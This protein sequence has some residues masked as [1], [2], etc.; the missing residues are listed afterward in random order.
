MS[1]M[2]KSVHSQIANKQ[3]VNKQTGIAQGWIAFLY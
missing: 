1:L 3:D 2:W